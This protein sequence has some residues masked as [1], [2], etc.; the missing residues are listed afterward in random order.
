MQV[1][2]H[3]HALR[4]PFQV[5]LAPGRALDRS[6]YVFLVLGEEIC[7]VDCGVRGSESMIF[8][9]LQQLGRS[10]RDLSKLVLTHAHPDHIGAAPA[11]VS[12]SGCTVFAHAAER[13]WIEDVGRH[14]RER[15]V[16]GFET[17]VEGSVRVGVELAEG[18]V[19]ELGTGVGLEVLETPGHS[20]GSISLLLREDGALMAGDA[21]PVPTDFPI[22]VDVAASVR[23]LRKL[24]REEGLRVLLSAWDEPRRGPEVR[25]VLDAALGHLE[26][27]HQAVWA[28]AAEG[29]ESERA[30][31]AARVLERL[32]TPNLA[33]NPLVLRSIAA[34]LAFGSSSLL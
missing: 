21:V 26:R 3:V 12:A 14:A 25:R 24:A 32:G 28:T 4:I 5:P 17:L 19:V 16:P 27:V 11:V 9:Y 29:L 23:S 8:D 2:E 15:P 34:H 1:T 13:T 7:L 33:V 30:E 10:P 18:G 6:V 22:Y 20:V 31:F